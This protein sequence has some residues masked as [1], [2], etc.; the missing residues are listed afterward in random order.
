V[1]LAT[2]EDGTEYRNRARWSRL[3]KNQLY[4]EKD[5]VDVAF[6]DGDQIT[7]GIADFLN[8]I[9][10]FKEHS[11]H[12]F[13]G[14]NPDDWSLFKTYAFMGTKSPKS[15]LLAGDSKIYY[16]DSL[17]HLRRLS[18][19]RNDAAS[20][21]D[22]V[23]SDKLTYVIPYFIDTLDL[24]KLNMANGVDYKDT[25]WMSVCSTGSNVP[26]K[27][28]I[29]DY[30]NTPERVYIFRTGFTS[31]IIDNDGLLYGCDGT[32]NYIFQLDIGTTDDGIEI[33]CRY[34]SP[35]FMP[36][37]GTNTIMAN[38]KL[39]YDTETDGAA[40]LKLYTDDALVETYNID[41]STDTDRY[42]V[43]PPRRDVLGRYHQIEINETSDNELKITNLQIKFRLRGKSY[44]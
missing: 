28:I 15:I 39:Q 5:Y 40:E 19:G 16:L 27:T 26:D 12:A 42:G 25:I 3:D 6:G 1:H 43:N 20:N 34:K 14:T 32:S 21:I 38:V 23:V 44:S 36:V 37:P 22:N 10:V 29:Y 2:I 13:T 11:V 30:K 4:Y 41:F 18:S 24:T 35:A 17:A 8:S 33:S 31:F 9:Y 7:G